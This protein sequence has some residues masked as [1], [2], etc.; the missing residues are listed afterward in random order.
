[1]VTLA[2]TFDGASKFVGTGLNSWDTSSVTN[3][4]FIFNEASKFVGTGLSSW[5]TASV[6][7]LAYAFTNAGAMNVDMSGWS[8]V[9]VVTLR[10]TFSSATAF[11]GTGL[12]KW[13]TTSVTNIAGTFLSASSMNADLSGW[14]LAKVSLRVTRRK[15][16]VCGDVKALMWVSLRVHFGWCHPP[17]VLTPLPP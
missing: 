9:N 1:M 8:V 3:L 14:N 2:T 13:I 7:T 11:V 6:T 16:R 4:A 10:D 5:D 12:A 17:P 15:Y